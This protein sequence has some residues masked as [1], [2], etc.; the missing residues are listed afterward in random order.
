MA[1]LSFL[2]MVLTPIVVFPLRLERLLD[3]PRPP[4]LVGY[5]SLGL[6]KVTSEPVAP[7]DP[8]CLAIRLVWTGRDLVGD[9]CGAVVLHPRPPIVALP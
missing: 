2:R 5:E 8:P 6:E 9:Q 7:T 3:E 4:L 1:S